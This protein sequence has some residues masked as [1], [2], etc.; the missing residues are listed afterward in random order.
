MALKKRVFLDLGAGELRPFGMKSRLL[1]MIEREQAK[2]ESKWR[3]IGIDLEAKPIRGRKYAILKA[4][5]LNY[6]K[7]RQSNSVDVIN[8]DLF[9]G[10]Y[11]FSSFALKRMAEDKN[12][13][14]VEVLK[15][16]LKEIKRV[17]KPN[18]RFYLTVELHFV[19][20]L[21]DALE[22]EGFKIIGT[23]DIAVL[24]KKGKLISPAAEYTLEK[25]GHQH[26]KILRVVAVK[27][28]A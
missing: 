15:D 1:Q 7:K 9:V 17:L 5:V 23:K 27:P 25:L 22:K 8:S 18:G 13:G 24:Q 6:L 4:D 19:L 28:G 16:Y 11:Y 26:H 14:K 20:N 3:L 10:S 21:K 2:K 12:I